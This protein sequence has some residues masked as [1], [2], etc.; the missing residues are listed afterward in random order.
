MPVVAS[1]DG[2]ARHI[3]LAQGVTDVHPIDDIYRE[4]REERRTNE[5]FRVWEPFMRAVGNDPKGG[6]KFT[7]RYLL[8][9]QGAKIVPYDEDAIINITGEVLA[10]DQTSPV[11]FES[12]SPGTTVLV[13]YTPPTAEIIQV[14]TSGLTLAESQA[15][16]DI[17]TNVGTLQVDVSDLGDGVF[18]Q[19][20]LIDAVDKNTGPGYMVMWDE[21]GVLLG[22]KEIYEA[23]VLAGDAANIG[24][25]RSG[26]GIAF[27]GVLTAGM[28]PP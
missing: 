21:L 1:W 19:K 10:D 9:L 14:G 5:A 7:P 28:P 16:L 20:V 23:H 2:V 24:Y 27:E 13:N 26:K 4:Y 18:G 6:G 22:H 25:T 8:L 17:N 15:L 11:Y 3:H 12:L